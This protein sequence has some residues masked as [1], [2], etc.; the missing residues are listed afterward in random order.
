MYLR[1]LKFILKA[2][3][4]PERA[5]VR[6]S[7]WRQVLLRPRLFELVATILQLRDFGRLQR[8]AQEKRASGQ[9]SDDYY[10]EWRD[11]NLGRALSRTIAT[12]RAA[13]TLLPALVLPPRDVG[14]EKLLVIGPRTVQEIY[15]CWLYG[16]AWK[17]ISAIDLFS[18]NR[19]IAVMN[20]EAMT[21]EDGRFAAVLAS[22][23]VTY[24][25]DLSRCFREIA[26]VLQPGGRLAFTHSY[27]PENDDLPTMRVPGA[28][29]LQA[30]REA[31]FVPYY[32]HSTE[33]T[34]SLGRRQTAHRVVAE[35]ADT[36]RR[37]LDPVA[38]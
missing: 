14:K 32:H 30:L 35:K 6:T 25:K 38:W 37:P 28:L 12:G 8:L 27:F 10:A 22:N 2:V 3:R 24:A 34:N 19:K 17:N 26:R 18:T 23:T 1:G 11:Y 16:F 31:G 9:A 33:F 13:E 15:L 20:M 21:F 7:L 36:A 29:M 5:R 4:A